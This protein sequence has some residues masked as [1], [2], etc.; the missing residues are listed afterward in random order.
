MQTHLLLLEVILIIVCCSS[1]S[2]LYWIRYPLTGTLLPLSGIYQQML[3]NFCSVS[4]D[5][6]EG[7]ERG[8]KRNISYIIHITKVMTQ[9]I[10]TCESC[11]YLNGN[12]CSVISNWRSRVVR[13]DHKRIRVR[14]FDDWLCNY[15]LSR[16]YVNAKR[17]WRGIYYWIKNAR[18][19]WLNVFVCCFYVKKFSANRCRIVQWMFV[20]AA[21]KLRRESVECAHSD[22]QWQCGLQ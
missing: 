9:S 7:A 11:Y 1:Y 19:I 4:I 16:R 5:A 10:H 17:Q 6:I 3:A 20:F 22:R 14:M 12:T 13:F 15:Q 8:I 21:I 18:I 2:P